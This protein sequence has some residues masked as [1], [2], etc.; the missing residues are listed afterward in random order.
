[1][2]KRKFE[3][4]S[5]SDLNK[6][7][8]RVLRLPMNGQYL[9]VGAPGTGKSVVA[10][11]RTLKLQ[12]KKS[13]YIFLVYNKVLE[14]FI[15]QLVADSINSKTYISWFLAS[16]RE[17]LQKNIPMLDN[18]KPDYDEILT[19]LR[20][21][22]LK[23]NPCYIVIDEGQDMPAKFYETLI[24]MQIANFFV[25]AD[26]NQQITDTNSNRMD[27]TNILALELNEVVELKE[28]FRNSYDIAKFAN[29]FYTDPSSPAPELPPKSKISI[30][31]PIL[32]EYDTSKFGKVIRG[33]IRKADFNS[34]WL[35]G[36]F[37]PNNKVRE[38]YYEEL[39]KALKSQN[40]KLDNKPPSVSTYKSGDKIDLDF[41]QGGIVVLNAQSVKGLEFD[42]VFIADINDFRLYDVEV[43]KKRFYVMVSRAITQVI[44]LQ[45]KNIECQVAR[46][47]PKDSNILTRYKDK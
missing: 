18:Y 13:D 16:V 32:Y 4:P 42:I 23:E 43:I 19:Q 17:S 26:F 7:Q 31:T 15:K 39:N 40:L 5:Y 6:G 45:Q 46:I 30:K 9:V 11:L 25:V 27:L 12:K 24:E 33:I 10:L 41:S 20:Q 28:N 36:V 8:D 1:M 38:K 47:L 3:L 29:Y 2:A 37:T 34:K 21:L 22:K 35:V 44:L 14:V